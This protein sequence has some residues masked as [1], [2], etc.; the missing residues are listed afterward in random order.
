MENQVEDIA[1]CSCGA[2]T[3]F[4]KDGTNASM[5]KETYLKEFQKT[6]V[7]T[8]LN[9]YGNCNHCVNHWG[10]DL[11]ACGSGETVGECDG[12]FEECKNKIP[13][14]TLGEH[15]IYSLWN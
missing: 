15:K 10:V 6:E 9:D 11:C 4:L 8:T 12:D 13:A 2:I 3:V 5:T 1:K 7:K 14:Q